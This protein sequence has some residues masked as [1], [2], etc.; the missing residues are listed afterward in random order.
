[1]SS[2]LYYSNL[3]I[4]KPE[5]LKEWATV[6]LGEFSDFLDNAM[7]RLVKRNYNFTYKVKSITVAIPDD[8]SRKNIHDA[9]GIYS[10][11]QGRNAI[12]PLDKK[13]NQIILDAIGPEGCVYAKFGDEIVK[14]PYR[15]VNVTINELA[16]VDIK[17][18]EENNALDALFDDVK[19]YEN[20][21]K[22]KWEGI[23][24]EKK[25]QKNRTIVLEKL[26]NSNSIH[27]KYN[28]YLI[29]RQRNA[30]QTLAMYP[31]RAH[32]PLLNLFQRK[33]LVKW[34]EVKDINS[35]TYHVLINDEKDGCDQQRE[36]VKKCFG[37][38]DFAFLEG[39]PGSGKTT[40]LLEVI[41]QAISRGKRILMVASTH[42]AVDNILERLNEVKNH[43]KSLIDEFGIIPIRIGDEGVVSEKIEKYRLDNFVETERSRLIG[44]LEKLKNKTDAQ[45][46]F[47]R[48]LMGDDGKKMV[49]S[50]ALECANLICGTTIGVLKAPIIRDGNNTEPIFD[51]MILDEASK[52]TFQEFLVP[53]LYARRWIIS[54]DTKQLSPYVDKEPIVMNLAN[55]PTLDGGEGEIDK[56]ICLDVFSASDFSKDKTYGKLI[57]KPE[58]SN[59]DQY[60][61][62]QVSELD[63]ICNSDKD[64]DAGIGLTIVRNKPQSIKEQ[65]DILGA[66]LVV[67]PEHLAADIEEY[68][69]PLIDCDSKHKF[70]RTVDRRRN[71][72]L[73]NQADRL[74]DNQ[75]WE[76]Q[77]EW[78]IS[79]LHELK[80]VKEK[81]ERLNF[82]V[83]LLL[84]YFERNDGAEKENGMNNHYTSRNEMIFN[85]IDAIRR[86]AHPSVLELLQYGFESKKKRDSD[87]E[88]ALFSGLDYGGSDPKILDSRH[89]LLSYQHR[90]HPEISEFP[91]IEIY[92]GES[93]NDSSDM[94]S[95]R[96]WKYPHYQRRRIWRSIR[97]NTDEYGRGRTHFNLAE[98]RE[99][100]DDLEK[101]MDWSKV[102]P[103]KQDND[104]FWHIAML[105][106]YTG[107]EKKIS[108]KLRN[109]GGFNLEGKYRYFTSKSHR[110]KIE[111][112]TVDRFQ[113]HEA[114]MVFLSFVRSG[115]GIGFLDNPNR[116]NV[117]ITRARYQLVIFGDKK[118]LARTDLL[119]KLVD[120]TPD[121]TIKYRG[122]R[123]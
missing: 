48:G 122:E 33:Y 4:D 95:I 58:N 62:K 40:A 94:K 84:P 86:I 87:S 9:D 69:H 123:K 64:R 59:I 68:L 49:E 31:N 45:N 17:E 28:T 16:P 89:V 34:G 79:R 109:L 72:L 10:D 75:K 78:R 74:N 57:I 39:P 23:K 53:A 83:K 114:D 96:E 82:E 1:M 77:I 27:I 105:T 19:V 14:Y 117:A 112:C 36:F 113:G 22:N 92:N 80:N 118:N 13:T 5:Q 107:Q 24:I 63:R 116:L 91:R 90:M 97:P 66:N 43:D 42:V 3:G 11:P 2:D 55:L 32:L 70:S 38:P 88:I 25:N 115:D 56:Q 120:N 26:P 110:V 50:Q 44:E 106:F 21:A 67:V 101:F 85:Q 54:G 47:Y 15:I 35:F 29:K 100:L 103:N 61:E 99:M 76:G 98:V 51:F 18:D 108:E 93:L 73:K 20:G 41:L 30:V 81:Y 12:G 52:T 60:I 121:G 111:V 119:R 71:A 102:N 37:T 46:T 7:R 104:G 6:R 65:L 8:K